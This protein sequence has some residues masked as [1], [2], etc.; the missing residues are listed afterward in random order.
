MTFNAKPTAHQGYTLTLN[1]QHTGA[2]A[3][4]TGTG[5]LILRAE[6]PAV[7]PTGAITNPGTLG[8]SQPVTISLKLTLKA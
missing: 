5:T 3:G 7:G 1:K 6:G 8:S 4:W 2:Y